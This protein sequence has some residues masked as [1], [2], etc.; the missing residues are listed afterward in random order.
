MFAVVQALKLLLPSLVQSDPSLKQQAM[1]QLLSHSVV[2]GGARKVAA[3]AVQTLQAYNDVLFKGECRFCSISVAALEA[4]RGPT[5][6]Q[7]AD[8]PALGLS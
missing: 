6:H 5:C 4:N 1:L 8:T 3:Q 7:P 2:L